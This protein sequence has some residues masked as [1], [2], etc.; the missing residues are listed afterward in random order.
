MK[1]IMI[2]YVLLIWILV[3]TG[4]MPWNLKTQFWSTFT[5]AVILFLLFSSSRFWAPV[6]LSNSSTIRAPH[7]VLSPL[8]A[9][10]VDEV[11]VDHNQLV[12]KGVLLYTLV[13][14]ATASSIAAI[15]AQIAESY[16][17]IAAIEVQLS[18][19]RKDLKRQKDLKNY[20]SEQSRDQL[21]ADI[22]Y[23]L[24]NI[25]GYYAGIEKLKAQKLE[26][27]YQNKLKKVRA[28][29]DGQ[30]STVNIANGTRTGNMHLYDLS[31]KFLEMR[32]PDQAYNHIKPGQFAE[33]YVNALPGKIFRGRVHSI[34]T[35]TGEAAIQVRQGS[36]QV[37]QFMKQNQTSHGR[38]VLIEFIEPPGINIPLGSTGSAWISAEK[39]HPALGFMDIIGAATVRLA[40]LKAY[41]GAM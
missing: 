10:E 16:A 9:Q 21:T 30:V 19:N 35:S 22:Q 24:A 31:K 4:V 34:T 12:K 38:T 33:F 3:K 2:P 8:F 20:A 36:E 39:P 15:D 13:D 17:Q 37:R 6:D 23:D 14:D 32:I 5:G 29:F 28:P 27:Q 18:N 26:A 7:A 40:S 41:F 25:K 11:F 1:E